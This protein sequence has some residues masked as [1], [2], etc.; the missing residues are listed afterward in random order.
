MSLMDLA[1]VK[2]WRR[3]LWSQVEGPLVLEAGVGTGLNIPHYRADCRVTALDK[4]AHFLARARSRA[5][6]K[7]AQQVEF[8]QGDV[9]D[10]PFPGSTFDTAV[11]AFLFCSVERPER[12]LQELHRV[13]KP[14]GQ[15]LLLEHC[16]SRGVLGRLMDLLAG[17]FYRLSGDFIATDTGALV[18]RAGFASVTSRNL[19]LDV[20]KIIRAVKE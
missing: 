20:V 5:L 2:R 1:L 7:P 18:R 12:G 17:P 4:G 6:G 14:G 9:Q 10:L 16:R 19:L 15:L 8:V 13:L 11:A 3:L